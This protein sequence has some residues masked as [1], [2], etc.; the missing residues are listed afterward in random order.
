MEEPGRVEG[1]SEESHH[2]CDRRR[3]IAEL[4]SVMSCNHTHLNGR[5]WSAVHHAVFERDS[6]R[7]VECCR[8]YRLEVNHVVP[9]KRG[10][11]P[12]DQDNLQAL[13]RACYIVKTRGE[14][15]RPAT[16][17]VAAWRRLVAEK[18]AS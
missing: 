2:R 11:D 6:W 14:N 7:C 9:L 15:R 13:C 4:N 1:K 12:W 16:P 8:A 17:A 10:G 18:K 5:R 3:A